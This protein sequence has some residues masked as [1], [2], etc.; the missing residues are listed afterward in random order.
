VYNNSSENLIGFVV[1][2]SDGM[3]LEKIVSFPNPA[4]EHTTI[5]Y[6]H[7]APGEDHEVLLEIFD[8][9]GRLVTSISRT[10]YETGFVSAPLE[11]D[12][13][14][15]SGSDLGAGIYPYRLTVTTSLGKSFINQ[16]LII[17]R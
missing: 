6:T 2:E 1:T 4:N 14:N 12:L 7:N 3:F 15:S 13:K 8:L 5:Q 11:W 9:S 17:I 16:K 10:Y